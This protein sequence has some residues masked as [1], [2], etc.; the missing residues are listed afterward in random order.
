MVVQVLPSFPSMMEVNRHCVQPWL[1]IHKI[2]PFDSLQPRLE[3]TR[4]SWRKAIK[5]EK[6]QV[7]EKAPSLVLVL[8]CTLHGLSYHV[9]D[10]S[11]LIMHSRSLRSNS[12]IHQK[13][14]LRQK[15]K[16][17]GTICTSTH[18][19]HRKP[20]L[21]FPTLLHSS[22]SKRLHLRCRRISRIS[23]W[24]PVPRA[25]R[26]GRKERCAVRPTVLMLRVSL[27]AVMG[28]L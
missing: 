23:S 27:G 14:K 18:L 26:T 16:E 1:Q 21:F 17:T 25:K 6:H 19:P 12:K 5:T 13:R 2:A 9:S 11:C 28:R 7:S 24:K 4:S 3:V 20:S 10:V 15:Q 8:L 22:L